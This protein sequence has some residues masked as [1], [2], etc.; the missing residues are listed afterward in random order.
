MALDPLVRT[1]DSKLVQ[2]TFGA[3]P[4]SGLAEGDAITISQPNDSF[5]T[6][7]GADGTIDRVNKN[8]YNVVVEINLKST[9]PTNQLFAEAHKLDKATNAGKAP[10]IIKDL[11]ATTTLLNAPQA[12]IVKP[13]DV[14]KSDGITTYTWTFHTGVADYTPAGNLV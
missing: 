14:T 11:N 2:S 4:V 6:V 8:V 13:A 3:I 5:E 9:S 7:Q 1:Y 10:L 12:W